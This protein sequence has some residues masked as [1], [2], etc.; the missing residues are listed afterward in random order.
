MKTRRNFRDTRIDENIS[1]ENTPPWYDQL[2]KLDEAKRKQA[3]EQAMKRILQAKPDTYEFINKMRCE[4]IG[5]MP[6]VSYTMPNDNE[7]SLD[8]TYIHDFSQYTPLFW[9]K[10]GGFA[11]F[12][13]ASLKYNDGVKGFTY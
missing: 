2:I 3:Y 4:L 13:N 9:C 8:V 11:F 7:N 12:V 5:F 10:Q 1:C 6:N